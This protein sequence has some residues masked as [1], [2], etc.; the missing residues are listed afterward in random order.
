M[1]APA[2]RRVLG[3]VEPQRASEVGNGLVVV[4][5]HER[6]QREL[7]TGHALA[8]RD[9]RLQA[10]PLGQVALEVARAAETVIASGLS[11]RV[12]AMKSQGTNRVP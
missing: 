1:L 12:K 3:Q 8:G 9:G 6:D 4:A 11:V 5:D 2:Q 10:V 7:L